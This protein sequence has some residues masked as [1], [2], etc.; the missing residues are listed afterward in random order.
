VGFKQFFAFDSTTIRLFS[1]VL[2]GVG[3]KHK[4]SGRQK[5]GMKVHVLTDIHADC[6]TFVKMSEARMHDK[7]FLQYLT[8]VASCMIVFDK[9]YNVLFAICQMDAGRHIFRMPVER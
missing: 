9:A 5:G 6:A 2:K 8:P 4:D 7:K 1:E 3:R